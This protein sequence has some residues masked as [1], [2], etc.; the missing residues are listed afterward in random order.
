M[1]CISHIQLTLFYFTVP[2]FID[3]NMS[4]ASYLEV[5]VNH[6]ITITCIVY[7]VPEPEIKWL[8]GGEMINDASH[9]RFVNK[10]LSF[11]CC[12]CGQ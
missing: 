10:C 6:T 9:P 8:M 12:F 5:I 7:G 3:Y 2:P 1:L 4:S 11:V